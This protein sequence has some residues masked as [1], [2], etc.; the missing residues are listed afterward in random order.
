MSG[1]G[2]SR[3]VDAQFDCQSDKQNMKES[4]HR[5]NVALKPSRVRVDGT[6][7]LDKNG[8]VNTELAETGMTVMML[9]LVLLFLLHHVLAIRSNCI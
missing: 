2:Y 8:I 9:F 3:R 5:F 6:E 7:V 4:T 1:Y